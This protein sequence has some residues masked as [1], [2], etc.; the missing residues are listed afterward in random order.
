MVM[1]MMR[2]DEMVAKRAPLEF[3]VIFFSDSIIINTIALN[4]A[5]C[6]REGG[7]N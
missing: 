2:G 6:A 5:D 4:Y 1:V 7:G 3:T